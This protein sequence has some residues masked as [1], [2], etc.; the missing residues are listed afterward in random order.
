MSE[1][2]DSLFQFCRRSTYTVS[3]AAVMAAIVSAMPASATV[4]TFDIE[5]IANGNGLSAK[6]ALMPDDYPDQ[7]DPSAIEYGTHAVSATGSPEVTYQV[8]SP[9][10]MVTGAPTYGDGGTGF[11]PNLV[12]TYN[13]D[14]LVSFHSTGYSGLTNVIYYNKFVSDVIHK[15]LSIAS[16]D[17]NW[18]PALHSIDIGSWSGVDRTFDF[19]V[20]DG[21]HVL[22]SQLGITASAT[23]VTLDTSDF[24]G[25]LVADGTGGEGANGVL[26]IGLR[27]SGYNLN[28]LGIDNI[29]ISQTLVPEPATVGL[30]A[31]GLGCVLCRRRKPA[32]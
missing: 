3:A 26:S 8:R 27:V 28:L 14:D 17:P 5:G 10:D 15:P 1:R 24:G 9:F 23:H 11:T 22:Y 18:A 25:P 12:V 29:H 13:I 19:F 21:T 31:L 20:F 7:Y 30:L 16:D 4:L 6:W 2:I 32:A